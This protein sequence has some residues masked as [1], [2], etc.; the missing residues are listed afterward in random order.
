MR[1][2]LSLI[3]IAALFVTLIPQAM[4]APTANAAGNYFVLPNESSQPGSP[5]IVT[6]SSVT[7]QGTLNG[8]VGTSISYHVDQMVAGNVANNTDEITTGIQTSAADNKVN[9]TAVPLFPGLNRIVLSGVAGAQTVSESIYIEYRNSPLLYDLKVTFENRDYVL[10][11]TGTLMLQTTSPVPVTN[12]EFIL[13]GKAP[14]A[15]KV[16][17]VINGRTFEFPVTSSAQEYRFATSILSLDKGMNTVILRVHNNGQVIETTRQIA[18]YNGEVTFYDQKFVDASGKEFPLKANMDVSTGALTGIKMKGKV[19]LPL[20]LYDLDPV[21]TPA[22]VVDVDDIETELLTMLKMEMRSGS[23]AA[24]PVPLDNASVV[25]EPDPVLD[26]TKFITVSYTFNL[27]TPTGLA[28]DTAYQMRFKVPNGAM[29]H[30]TS[31]NHF[32]FRDSSKAY[33]ADINYLSGFNENLTTAQ[34]SALQGSDI[35][36]DGAN[37]YSVPMAIEVLV[38]NHGSIPIANYS[39][40]IKVATAS[41]NAAVASVLKHNE[42]VYIKENNVDVPFLRMIVMLEAL[43]SSGTNSLN[44]SLN[45]TSATADTKNIILKLLYGPYVKFD[46]I[47]ENMMIHYDDRVDTASIVLNKLG[48]FK[49][50]LYNIANA[51][52][53]VYSGPGQTAFLYVNNVEIPIAI[54]GAIATRFVPTMTDENLFGVLLKAGENT[55]KF[56]F[57]TASNSYENTFTFTIM[58]TNLPSIPAKDTLGIFPYSASS[59]I[60]IPNDK[61]FTKQGSIYTTK[62][63][64]YNVHGTFDFADLGTTLADVQQKLTN[65]G[66]SAGKYVLQ[67]ESPNWKDKLTWDLTKRMAVVQNGVQVGVLN[68]AS[69]VSRADVK[70]TFFYELSNQTFYFIIDGQ[71]MPI[72]GSSQVYVMTVFNDGIQGPRAAYR[73]ELNSISIPYTIWAPL[74]EEKTLNQNFVEVIISSPGADSIVIGKETAKPVSYIDYTET[75]PQYIEAF[76]VVVKDLRPDK[77]TVI[78]ITIIRGE[79][80][81]EEDLIVN[82]RPANI[83]GAQFMDEMAASHKMFN[84]ALQLT[85]PRN[86][87]LVRPTHDLPQNLATQVYSEHNLLFAMANPEDGVINRH[88]FKSMPADYSTLNQLAGERYIKYDFQDKA[89]QFIMVSPLFWIDGGFADNPD[90]PLVY[91]PVSTGLD[92]YPF[93]LV[94]DSVD[95]RFNERYLDFGR[96]LIPSAPG[97]L[98]LS[99]DQNMSQSAGSTV[100][101]FRF[102]P[103][104]LTWENVGGVVDDKKRT[105]TVPF[106]KF[107]YYVAAKL[108]RGYNDMIDHDYAREAMQAIYAKGIMNAVDSS[109]RFGA[110]EYVTRGEFTRMIVR[111]LDLPLNYSGSLHF[112]YYPWTISN[113]TQSLAL[114]DYRYIETA[115]RAGIVDGMRPGFFEEDA[116]LTREQAATILSRALNLKTETDAKKANAA[117]AK[118]FKDSGM[119]DTYAVPH[120][121]ALQKKAFIVGMPIDPND[122][123]QGLVFSP[124]ARLLRSDAAIIIARVMSDLK[125]LPKIYS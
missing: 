79:E 81:I 103:Y 4:N 62:Q 46:S 95:D 83:P 105:I 61:N 64:Q 71:Q 66:T 113:A 86:T 98:T 119:V 17:V 124:K 22:P 100:T 118:A 101:V 112:S 39:T 88:E 15:Q 94:A 76:S 111:A 125:K 92:P 23:A 56:V 14:N 116:H 63:A 11:D 35:P 65:W 42:V 74:E 84:N 28:Y 2:I 55:V 82:Y 36:A 54:D 41:N 72:D 44:I 115:A 122:P 121:L 20:P 104:N 60:P 24:T 70:I 5:R 34:L 47:V 57:R 96:E 9:I 78:P 32:T 93:P 27:P 6:T 8:V 110:D 87:K 51:S 45:H 1:K 43:P 114:Y 49:G 33:I 67:I 73:L 97:K 58:P 117:L 3:L 120:I 19:I 80:E 108:T 25:V 102:D 59:D 53:I 90:T 89:R 31:W 91:D 52:Q 21:V 68:D 10:P 48:D 12:G 50:Q 38:R 69:E 109:G 13:S 123:K 77:E 26:T 106:S 37:V 99:Y 16:T 18:F 40:L 7:L 75:T 30:E 29:Y 85:F 107:G